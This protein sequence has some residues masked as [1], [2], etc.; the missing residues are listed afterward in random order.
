VQ[1]A[2]DVDVVTIG[3]AIVDVL[4]STGDELV[5]SF[6]LAKGTMTL[7]DH[8]Q[9]ERIYQALGPATAVSGGCAANTAAGLTSLG[10]TAAFLGK[11]RDDALGEVFSNDIHAAGVHYRVPPATAGPATGRCMIMV[12]A[13]AERTMCT[14]LGAGDFVDPQDLDEAAIAAAQVV[15][16][17]G[18]L[19]G[20]DSTDATV[21]RAFDV[22]RAAQTL[23]SLSLSDPYWVELHGQS[24]ARLLDRVDI[25]FCNEAEACG[26]TGLTDAER[27]AAALADRCATVAVTFGARGSLVASGGQ[28][29]AV[30]AEPVARV[31]DTTGAGDL[32]A[33]GFLYGV[34]EGLD[35]EISGRLGSIAAAEVIA[36]F[37][38][39]PLQPLS[40]LVRQADLAS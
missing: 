18:Y 9:S 38:A 4:A 11:V 10:A 35:V 12:T 1:P 8:E 21:E 20:L 37:G 19:C 3:H 22:A 33:A 27:A 26:I 32:Y 39:R 30:A 17:E 7:V 31:L 34:V 29:F 2:L 40:E 13:D 5:A 6:G 14:N 36:H 25:L 16:L 15:Y 24:L 28:T 23:V